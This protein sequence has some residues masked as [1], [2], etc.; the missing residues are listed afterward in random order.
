MLSPGFDTLH[1]KRGADGSGFSAFAEDNARKAMESPFIPDNWLFHY[2]FS[3]EQLQLL[4]GSCS[5]T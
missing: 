1:L 5:P 4:S 3:D 2:H